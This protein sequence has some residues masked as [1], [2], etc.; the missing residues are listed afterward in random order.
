[1]RYYREGGEA[2]LARDEAAREAALRPIVAELFDRSPAKGLAPHPVFWE[3]AREK[4]F[5]QLQE[6]LARDA[7][8]FSATGFR[9]QYLEW[10]F[11]LAG[12]R[13]V[14]PR[15][16]PAPLVL[17]RG[18]D[19]L[20]VVGKVDRIDVDDQGNF[21]VYDYKS[22]NSVPSWS[23]ERQGLSL[24]LRVYLR[25]V[26]EL[27]LPEGRP[28]GAAY[29][30]LPKADAREGLWHAEGAAKLNRFHRKRSAGLLSEEEWRRLLEETD[31]V[32]HEVARGVRS[33][34]FPLTVRTDECPRC[35]FRAACRVD[36]T[37]EL[38]EET[39]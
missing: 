10:G 7:A 11:G 12:G 25:A 15:S 24:Q 6:V 37:A 33:G 22:G 23:D 35:R 5:Q 4:A 20:T 8:C 17:G 13:D 18:E 39:P 14:D 34:E 29:F 27:L 16:S 19:A 1:R 2:A 30:S 36:E 38:E 31:A 28:V 32:A 26:G 21:V 9:P 3:A